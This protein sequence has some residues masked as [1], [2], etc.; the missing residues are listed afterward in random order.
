MDRKSNLFVTVAHLL[1]LVPC[2]LVIYHTGTPT[3]RLPILIGWLVAAANFTI[4][5]IVNLLA[6]KK[7]FE[8]FKLTVFAG[9]GLR[10]GL[11]LAIIFFVSKYKPLWTTPFSCSLLSCFGIYIILEVALFFIKSKQIKQ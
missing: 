9:S 6:M 7:D 4:A 10:M 3:D 11:M 2:L 1:T 5:V 8:T